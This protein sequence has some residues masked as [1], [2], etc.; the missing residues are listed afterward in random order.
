SRSLSLNT[1]ANSSP[2]YPPKA[3]FKVNR[4][5]QR[6]QYPKLLP[7]VD[8]LITES[9]YGNRRHKDSSPLNDLEQVILQTV[10]RK[11]SILIPSFA[12]GRA[13]N[14]MY[15]LWKLK[16]ENRIPT[17]P[18]YLNSP[19]ANNV[20]EVWT[21][22]HD[23][24]RLSSQESKEVCATVDYV[25]NVE[26]SKALNEKEDSL[27]IISGSGMLTGGRILHHLKKFGPDA[28]N[29]ILLSG[30]Q[31]AGTRGE[32]LE[33]GATEIKIHGEYV[34]INAEVKVL[35]NMSAHADYQEII[36]WFQ[37]SKIT[38][39]KVFITHGEPSASDELRRRLT[40]TLGWACTVPGLDELIKV[41]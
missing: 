15:Y 21:R 14:L 4:P 41:D 11:G 31:A 39:K 23:L 36:H 40:E 8:Y 33:R 17:L 1:Y 24:H 7:A 27:L 16:S 13:Q 9:T 18:M 2:K 32:A 37:E 19:M 26:E 30:F 12:V 5:T 28:K 3:I 29:T 35:D 20:N 6:L 38:P 10:R 34:P 22:Y 25:Q